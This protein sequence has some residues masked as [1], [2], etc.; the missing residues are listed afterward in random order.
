MAFNGGTN[1]YSSAD[2][3]PYDYDYQP[4]GNVGTYTN[5]Y[6]PPVLSQ[7]ADITVDQGMDNE[8]LRLKA[9]ELARR[10]AELEKR[11]REVQ[12]L[13]H[14]P[15]KKNWPRCYPIV[16]HS[17]GEI[18]SDFL[19][20]KIAYMGY[21]SWMVLCAVMLLNAFTAYITAFYPAAG[22]SKEVSTMTIVQ[23]LVIS[24]AMF[25]IVIPAHFFLSYWPLYKAMEIGAI[26]RFILFF[27]GYAVAILFCAIGCAGYLTYGFSGI[28]TA[29]YYFPTGTTG[30]IPAFVCNLV[31]AVIWFAMMIDFIVIFI[32]GIK[33]FRALKGSLNKI[34]EYGTGLVQQGAA[35]AISG[36]VKVGLSGSNNQ[37]V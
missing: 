2:V 23:Y 5:A 29:I 27:I 25:F 8:A 26:P 34:K 36:A 13:E 15:V 14:M 12:N 10:E 30:S 16:Y 17:I 31:M 28:V 21:I 32:L 7:P 20:R 11:E 4:Q 18:P 22:L 3:D 19:R 37:Q 33:V 9:M 35:T 1:P 6:A 24:T